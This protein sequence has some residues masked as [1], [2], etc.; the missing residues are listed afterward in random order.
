MN[1]QLYFILEV[2]KIV[3]IDSWNI[4][5][6]HYN[7]DLFIQNSS[8]NFM[9]VHTFFSMLVSQFLP[10]YVLFLSELAARVFNITAKLSQTSPDT[11]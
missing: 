10:K 5:V 7:F 9:I 1:S 6:M 4:L 11:P 8:N 2:T 3:S